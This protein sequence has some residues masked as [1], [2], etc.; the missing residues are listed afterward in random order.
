[1]RSGGVPLLLL[2]MA[3][4]AAGQPGAADADAPGASDGVEAD[5][6]ASD[7]AIAMDDGRFDVPASPGED[8]DETTGEENL[9]ANI[10]PDGA[11]EVAKKVP[12]RPLSVPISPAVVLS[13]RC[14]GEGASDSVQCDATPSAN[15]LQLIE[16]AAEEYVRADGRFELAVGL[17]VEGSGIDYE[18]MDLMASLPARRLETHNVRRRLADAGAQVLLGGEANFEVPSDISGSDPSIPTESYLSE[19]LLTILVEE[20]AGLLEDI[21]LSGEI[22]GGDHWLTRLVGYDASFEGETVAKAASPPPVDQNGDSGSAEAAGPADNDAVIA[23]NNSVK[24]DTPEESSSSNNILLIIGAA[25]A[26]VSLLLLVG[27]LWYAHRTSKKGENKAKK[28]LDDSGAVFEPGKNN[29]RSSSQTSSSRKSSLFK[30]K[31]SRASNNSFT[32]GQAESHPPPPPAP[33][34]DQDATQNDDDEDEDF[35]LARAALGHSA[36]KGGDVGSVAESQAHTFGD[37]MSYAFTVEGE[38]LAPIGGAP[39]VEETQNISFDG[40][41]GDDAL[42][43]AG[44]MASFANDKGVFRWNEDGTKMVYTPKLET[45]GSGEQNGFVFDEGKKKWVVKDQ[46]VGERNVSFANTIKKAEQRAG[47]LVTIMRTRSGDSAGTGMTGL[48]E[49][50]YGEVALDKRSQSQG[51]V[52][53]L[54]TAN[55]SIGIGAPL[56]PTTPTPQDEGVEVPLSGEEPAAIKPSS[57]Y[58]SEFAPN[59]NLDRYVS[60]DG[61]AISGFTDFT[62][63][64]KLAPRPVT[65]EL[66]QAVTPER[67]PSQNSDAATFATFATGDPGR[68]MP[69]KP[70]S[71]PNRM[72]ITEDLPFDE[73]IPFDERTRSGRTKKGGL[74]VPN[75]L[76][77]Y[78]DGNDSVS[79]GS[80]GTASSEQIVDDLN[81]LSKFMIQRKRSSK[82]QRRRKGSGSGK[83]RSSFGS[84]R[85]RGLHSDRGI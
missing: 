61:S 25:G 55:A 21:R 33:F 28:A 57:S 15:E 50:S 18:G 60:D 24:N 19:L 14:S 41:V 83:G 34:V 65:P 74:V 2:A 82:S 59:A 46:V 73:G 5:T 7:A 36:N 31:S 58:E 70:A 8:V 72:K 32:T 56:T 11:S 68:I 37:D 1:M 20:E 40:V 6:I 29:P 4:R 44:G 79:E 80:T 23:A 13:L 38:S 42:I 10:P 22:L 17:D 75:V 9:P 64:A 49:F 43:G 69:K 39:D 54:G 85:A 26:G 30:K 27:G 84:S 66:R 52:G 71:K 67:V 77:D 45:S 62:A 78:V 12:H 16:S 81:Q 51:T 53:T 47:P 3:G 35:L 76:D 48:T 63:A